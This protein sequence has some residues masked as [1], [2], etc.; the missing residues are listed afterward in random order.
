MDLKKYSRSFNYLSVFK[1][2]K[3]VIP[4]ECPKSFQSLISTTYLNL[5]DITY[6]GMQYV[7]VMVGHMCNFSTWEVKAERSRIQDQAKLLGYIVKPFPPRA[8][9][10]IFWFINMDFSTLQPVKNKFQLLKSSYRIWKQLSQ[11]IRGEHA[12]RG[13]ECSTNTEG[14]APKAI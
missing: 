4:K 11:S 10:K 6:T 1:S 5:V 12:V 14:L 13:G 9:H 2:Q 7:L 3:S 8:A